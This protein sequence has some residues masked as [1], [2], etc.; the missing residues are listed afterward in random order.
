MSTDGD[1]IEQSI[2]DAA[3]ADNAT[4]S[5]ARVEHESRWSEDELAVLAMLTTGGSFPTVDPALISALPAEAGDATIAAVI[6][7]LHA[8]GLLRAPEQEVVPVGI[9]AEIVSV[10]LHPSSV[11]TAELTGGGEYRA[12]WF[13]LDQSRMCRIDVEPGGVRV[14]KLGT[15]EDLVD[16]ICAMAGLTAP[17]RPAADRCS[18]P[19]G[20]DN[21][22][23]EP[24]RLMLGQV[25]HESSPVRLVQAQSTWMGD[26]VQLGAVAA[27]LV[28][29][30]HGRVAEENPPELPEVPAG[31]AGDLG[32]E[33]P[34]P[35]GARSWTLGESGTAAVRSS[36]R[37]LLSDS[38][39]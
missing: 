9:A 33:G 25:L 21:P 38:R 12:A 27:F 19:A 7:S 2:A 8:R 32:L 22:P 26:G 35:S 13:G 18:G 20:A 5:R 23:T 11:V 30:G 15:A 14:V 1:N 34:I 39:L 3:S 6:R 37:A 28:L 29:D 16:E 36:L 31:L 17:D 24:S 4:G 10:A